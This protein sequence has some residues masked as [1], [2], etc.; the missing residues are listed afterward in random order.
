MKNLSKITEGILGD[1]ARRDLSGGRKREDRIT[2]YDE[3]MIDYLLKTF[4]YEIIL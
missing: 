3:H 4:A 2:D 1:I